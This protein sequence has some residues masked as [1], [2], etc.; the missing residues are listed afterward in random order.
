MNIIIRKADEN[1]FPVIIS[2]IKEFSIFQKTPWKVTNTLDQMIKDKDIFQCLVAVIDKEIVG[3]A[4]FF[5]TYYSWTGK[6]LYLD[7]LYIK[8]SFRK[9]AVGKKL[10]DTI[11][12]LAKKEQCKNIRWLVSNWNLNAID[13]YKNMGATID[14]VD[15]NCNFKI[16]TE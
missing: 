4:T 3:F 13:F 2:L 14:E 6:G 11:I 9:Q 16:R 1:D 15:L 10:L 5:F 12:D 7:D 8:D